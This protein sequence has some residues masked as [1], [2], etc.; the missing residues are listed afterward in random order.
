M[1]WIGVA[2][3]LMAYLLEFSAGV[4]CFD[5]QIFLDFRDAALVFDRRL[6]LDS[7]DHIG[8]SCL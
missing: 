2:K 7:P 4:G 1:S 3:K 5:A 8:V 6:E